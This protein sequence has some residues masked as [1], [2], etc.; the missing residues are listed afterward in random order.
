MCI[1]D[2]R[3]GG[4]AI[5][6]E[7][8]LIETRAV[9]LH[10]AT[11]QLESLQTWSLATPMVLVDGAADAGDG[12]GRILPIGQLG[13]WLAHLPAALDGF[14]RLRQGGMG[15]E[16]AYDRSLREAGSD[17][18]E[19]WERAQQERPLVCHDDL[20]RFASLCQRGFARKPRE[21]LVVVR[22]PER[23][24]AFLLARQLQRPGS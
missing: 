18:R 10:E 5:P 7:E 2:S 11:T 17:F 8:R 13:R 12:D 21:L 6:Y 20:A 9:L 4:D 22:W 23:V 19:A 16:E 24:T 3:E 1:R 15:L 14:V